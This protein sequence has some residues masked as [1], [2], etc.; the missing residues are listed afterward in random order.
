MKVLL[1]YVSS[2]LVKSKEILPCIDL[3][4]ALSVFSF[5]EQMCKTST[6]LGMNK[7][8]NFKET[9]VSLSLFLID[10]LF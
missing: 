10:I 4:G 8:K 5:K 3:S 2:S 1:L 6:T 7:F 9:W